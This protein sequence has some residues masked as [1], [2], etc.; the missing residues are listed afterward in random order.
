MIDEAL[1][2]SVILSNQTRWVFRKRPVLRFAKIYQLKC[3]RSNIP[4][5]ENTPFSGD[6]VID[7][8]GLL[9]G[10][11]SGFEPYDMTSFLPLTLWL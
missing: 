9:L 4:I 8:Y 6:H 2:H 5:F 10:S 1:S 7:D 11:R 3:D